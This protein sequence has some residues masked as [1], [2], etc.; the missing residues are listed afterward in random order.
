MKYSRMILLVLMCLTLTG[1]SK[2]LPDTY[3]EGSDYQYMEKKTF[4]AFHQTGEDV[5]YFAHGHYI[6]YM[7]EESKI[8]LPLCGKADCLH[9]KETDSEKKQNCNA[10]M[11]TESTDT[12]IAYCNGSLYYVEL[13]AFSSP[14]LYRLSADG[15]KKEQMY[16]W[17]DNVRIEQWIVHRDVLY[18][19]EHIYLSEEDKTAERYAVKSLSLTGK[20]K[21]PGTI[22][23]VDEDLD[24]FTVAHPQAYGNFLYF[25][26][27]A[28]K[29]AEEEITQENY[30]KYQYLKTFIY[31]MEKQEVRELTLED[32]GKDD[33]IQGVTF[34]QG[35]VIFHPYKH[36]IDYMEPVTWYIADLDG[37]NAEVFMEGVGQGLAFLSDGKYLYLSNINMVYQGHDKGKRTYK[38]YDKNLKLVDTVKLPV[39]PIADIAIGTPEF[40]YILE[41]TGNGEKAPEDETETKEG[42]EETEWG[43]SYWDKSKIGSYQGDTF[44]L[45]D[46]KYE[47]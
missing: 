31:N 8:I 29:K 17:A 47:G 42:Q 26:V 45:T 46:I 3:Q 2:S 5:H 27:Y 1:C 21:K 24:V 7:D 12:G 43:V 15:T 33:V 35:K 40:M 6:Y 20:M 9:D 11:E 28:Q 10:Y 25:Q 38:I 19:V 44:E 18:Y 32:M 13:P 37:T 34:W 39:E 16:Q 22:Y 23:K 4:S 41:G 14:V 30:I 36:E